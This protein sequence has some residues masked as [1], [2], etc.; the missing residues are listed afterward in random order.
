[1]KII[2]NM[3]QIILLL[4]STLAIAFSYSCSTTKKAYEGPD[5]K[6]SQVAVV[7]RDIKYDQKRAKYTKDDYIYLLNVDSTTLVIPG[8]LFIAPA[9]RCEVL[10]GNHTFKIIC[11][12]TYHQWNKQD[13][14]FDYDF[15]HHNSGIYQVAF[16]A[17]A[18]HTYIICSDADHEKREVDIYVKDEKSGERVES[19]V[20]EIERYKLKSKE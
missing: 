6:R 18:G 9:Q 16:N 1:M 5:L 10:P 4:C 15:L 7:K 2:R 14:E 17:E 19:T 12:N 13:L 11:S 3:K 20:E 8:K